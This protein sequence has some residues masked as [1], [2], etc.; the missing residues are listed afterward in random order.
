MSQMS[1]DQQF[2]TLLRHHVMVF[3]G[4]NFCSASELSYLTTFVT[5]FSCSYN[6]ELKNRS[7]IPALVK[8]AQKYDDTIKLNYNPGETTHELNLRRKSLLSDFVAYVITSEGINLENTTHPKQTQVRKSNMNNGDQSVVK[9][10]ITNIVARPGHWNSL[11]D[12][13]M[14]DNYYA[15]K[16]V[17]DALVEVNRTIASV[18]SKVDARLGLEDF[19][20]VYKELKQSFSVDVAFVGQL[21]EKLVESKITQWQETRRG[22]GRDNGCPTCHR[23][24]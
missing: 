7:V 20:L 9:N 18:R 17:K 22:S 23:P 21:L 6:G 24:Y 15:S 1:S 3:V 13:F 19:R 4:K 8:A 16:T 14:H 2:L 11:H 12:R 5:V 10:Y